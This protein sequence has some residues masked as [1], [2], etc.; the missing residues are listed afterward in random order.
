MITYRHSGDGLTCGMINAKNGFGGY[1]G[2]KPFTVVWGI[3]AG[4]TDMWTFP[5]VFENTPYE[6]LDCNK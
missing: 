1:V 6:K 3:K 5:L 4:T 2:E